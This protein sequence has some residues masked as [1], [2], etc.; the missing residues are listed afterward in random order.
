[1]K[2][3]KSSKKKFVIM[4]VI[5]VLLIAL[6]AGLAL[7]PNREDYDEETAKIQDITTY[8]NFNG[9]IGAKDSQ[10]V[11]SSNMLPIKKLYV[12]EGDLV[13]KGD[14]L[15]ILDDSNISSNIEQA[16][17][18][19][20]IARINYE[21]I[22]T[23]AKDQQLIQVS[24]TLESAQLTFDDAELNL[25]RTTELF[26]KGSISKQ[27]LEQAQKVYDTAKIQLKSAQQNYNITE[28]SS[29]QNILTAKEQL[30]QA[31]ASYESSKAQ[32]T[33]S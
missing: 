15:Y 8:Y 18:G 26:N 21:K 17:A 22:S 13:K 30:R 5:F 31:Q 12:K 19:V 16:A 9:N 27:A 28:K 14:I 6:I 33:N 11:V 10:I 7:R 3:K 2:L 4:S 1:M 25:E 20:E 24:N 23:T 29:E 32:M